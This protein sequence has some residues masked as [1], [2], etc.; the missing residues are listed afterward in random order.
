MTEVILKTQEYIKEKYQIGTGEDKFQY[1]YEHTMRVAAIG[2][3]IARGEKMNEEALIL[4]CLLHDIGYV[5]CITHEDYDTHGRI[6][7][8]MAR[9]YLESI[10]YDFALTNTIVF[11]I[12]A[13]TEE[14]PERKP[15]SFEL[16]IA[17][18]DNIDRFDAYRL[19]EFLK[20]SDLEKKSSKEMLEIATKRFQR[21]TELRDYPNG[22]ET[23]DLLWKQKIDFQLDYYDRLKQQMS[24]AIQ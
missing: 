1:R 15:T 9:E 24:L 17:D 7:A 5:E 12:Y 6:S 4:G 21:L 19:Y 22:S 3:M 2:Q 11:G 10:H 14:Q 13:H 16:S 23:A 18:A 20:F 8:K